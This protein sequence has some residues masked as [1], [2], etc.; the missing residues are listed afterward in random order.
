MET[1]SGD[2]DEV[3]KDV[4]LAQFDPP[5]LDMIYDHVG[6]LAD[7]ESMALVPKSSNGSHQ[8]HLR[9]ILPAGLLKP[10]PRKRRPLYQTFL[11]V[12]LH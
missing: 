10:E 2:L 3:R 4:L 1:R 6:E 7:G 11:A 9:A 5:G 8:A 12:F